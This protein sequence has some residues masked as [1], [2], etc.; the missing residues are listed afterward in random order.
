MAP[1]HHHFEMKGWNEI[2]VT[3]RFWLIAGLFA[4]L[5][6]AI[7]YTGFITAGGVD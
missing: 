2:T 1:I 4:G 6:L 5:G 3:V 7:F